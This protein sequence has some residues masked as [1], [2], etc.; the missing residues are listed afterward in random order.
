MKLT[1]MATAAVLG[2]VTVA[3]PT[4]ADD[5]DHYAAKPS[6][7]LEEAVKNFSEYNERLADILA[8]DELSADDLEGIHQ[9]TYT[10]EV[11]LAKI[12]EEMADLPETLERL[13]LASEAPNAA[14]AQ[15]VGKVYLE[16]AQTVVK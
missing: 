16:T 10:L 2:L 4:M 11:A 8:K 1:A 5:V 14:E 3:A 7:T 15:G 12:N 9:L 13:H 6:E